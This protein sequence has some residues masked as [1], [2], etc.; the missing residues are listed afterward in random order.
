MKFFDR[1]R[2]K[3]IEALAIASVK[4]DASPDGTVCGAPE[5]AAVEATFKAAK[6]GRGID[7][8]PLPRCGAPAVVTLS[9]TYV[10]GPPTVEHYC[11]ACKPRR[12]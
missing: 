9:M 10:N 8:R 12:G 3:Q 5:R 4:E 1:F 2:R 11:E 6:P 7:L